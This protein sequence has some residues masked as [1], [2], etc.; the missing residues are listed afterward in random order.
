MKYICIERERERGREKERGE[1]GQS[2]YIIYIYIYIYIHIYIYIYIG[3]II[4]KVYFNNE[5]TNQHNIL[6]HLYLL[7]WITNVLS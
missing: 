4:I 5:Y 7:R 3:Y 1:E 6:N 2:R